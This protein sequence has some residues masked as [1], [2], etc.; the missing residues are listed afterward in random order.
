[1]NNSYCAAHSSVE[2]SLKC[3]RCSKLICPRCMVSSPVGYR[4]RACSTGVSRVALNISFNEFF[5]ALSISV[6]GAMGCGVSLALLI[7]LLTRSLVLANVT[8]YIILI[9]LAIFSYYLGGVISLLV[10]RK[11]GKALKLIAGVGVLIMFGA[12]I[13]GGG[14]VVSVG[15]LVSLVLSIWLAVVKL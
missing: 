15:F 7:D 13:F 10:N 6:I 4:C 2:T 14:M 5:K 3:A 8:G 1:M 11:R 9:L 12:T